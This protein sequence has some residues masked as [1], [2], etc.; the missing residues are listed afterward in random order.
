MVS[1]IDI[2]GVSHISE[3]VSFLRQKN[4]KEK[5]IILPICK[6][7]F[8]DV[9][10]CKSKQEI[11]DFS[12]VKGQRLAKRAAEIAAAGFHNMLMS[13]PPGGG[14]S[15]IAKRIPGIL[16]EMTEEEC[17]E[18][19][20]IYSVAGKL[21]SD[22]PLVLQRPFISP[23]HTTTYS[24]LVGGGAKGKPRAEK[25]PGNGVAEK[26]G[27]DRRGDAQTAQYAF[28]RSATASC[29]GK[30]LGCRMPHCSAR[31]ALQRIGQRY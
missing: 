14:K 11:S 23:H 18:V 6:T 4:I 29:A 25:G 9:L 26:G 30:S 27:A 17:L 19:S 5:D 22:Q 10:N 31:R 15:M 16:P 1:G 3:L 8:C 20:S 28:G 2:R 24:A 21:S 13:G 7:S 12:Q